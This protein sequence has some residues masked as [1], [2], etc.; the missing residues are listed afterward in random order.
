MHLQKPKHTFW[1]KQINEQLFVGFYFHLLKRRLPD[2]MV[3]NSSKNTMASSTHASSSGLHPFLRMVTP[4]SPLHDPVTFGSRYKMSAPT[5]AA[6]SSNITRTQLSNVIQEVFQII[7]SD[8]DLQEEEELTLHADS[9]DTVIHRSPS[10]TL[11]ANSDS[12][13]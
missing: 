5:M 9:F 3:N 6:D 10:S 1:Q 7:D 12:A 8:D 11:V 4:S 13:D 2:A